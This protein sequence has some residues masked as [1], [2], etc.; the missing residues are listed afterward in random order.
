MGDM[1]DARRI[2]TVSQASYSDAPSTRIYGLIAGLVQGH[3]RIVPPRYF[4]D[5]VPGTVLVETVK[6]GGVVTTCRVEPSGRGADVTIETDPEKRPGT[7][8]R[9][10]RWPAARI[11]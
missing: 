4:R 11:L 5:P 10:E 2:Y 7:A 9:L 1:A 3:P 6:G 8:G